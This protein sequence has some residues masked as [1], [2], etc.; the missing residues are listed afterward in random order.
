M[1][2]AVTSA[3]DPGLAAKLAYGPDEIA[4]RKDLI[5]LGPPHESAL[6]VAR[7]MIE[8]RIDAIVEEFDRRQMLVPEI[9]AIIGEPDRLSRLAGS[10]RRYI[11]SLFSG[12]YDTG[13]VA[14]RLRIGE[15]HAVLKVPPKL[16]LA[17]VHLL[18]ELLVDHLA[19][20]PPHPL[21]I[22]ALRKILLFDLQIVIDTYLQAEID[23]VAAVDARVEQVT[24]EAEDRIRA[25]ERIAMTDA[26]TGLMNRRALQQAGT[27][28]VDRAR[29]DGAP[30]SILFMD[31]DD[32]KAIND[33]RG[34]HFGDEVLRRVG[35]M[36]A[37]N[38]RAEDTAFRFGGDEFCILLPG[39]GPGIAGRV[40]TR[41]N[42]A[43][44]E[45][46]DG[47]VTLSIGTESWTADTLP[48]FAGVVAAVDDTM[49]ARK[50]LRTRA[51]SAA[52]Q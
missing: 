29:A 25:I 36:I 34:H 8:A 10:M 17:T 28:E 44:Q 14:A 22:K 23:R 46:F 19:D 35:G 3:R 11:L 51:G 24:R 40:V 47:K 38:L 33:T 16:Y 6:T 48:D 27:R 4:R 20:A 50:A 52:A 39:A 2:R 49:Y 42:D 18:E 32:F 37:A 1:D 26:L 31:V 7:P 13:Y 9:E 5:G 21:L 30:F 12:R 45:A 43:L 15:V 41:L